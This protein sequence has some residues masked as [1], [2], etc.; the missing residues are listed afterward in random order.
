MLKVLGLGNPLYGDDAFGI[1]VLEELKKRNLD[2]T[3]AVE[4]ISLPTPSPWD[5]YETLREGE[6]FIIVDVMEEGQDHSIVVFPLDEVGTTKNNFRTIHDMNI[7]QVIDLL[8]VNGREVNGVVVATKGYSFGLSLEL[9]TEMKEN[10]SKAADKIT[11]LLKIYPPKT[12]NIKERKAL[13]RSC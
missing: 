4:F 1:F 2:I 13:L 6:F 11:E 7:N 5:I 9:S 3:T 8:R 12:V 10:V